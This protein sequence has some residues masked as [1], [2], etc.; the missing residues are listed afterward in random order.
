MTNNGN[1]SVEED[2]KFG[3]LVRCSDAEAADRFEDFLSEQN[4]ILFH[5]KFEGPGVA[6]YFGQASCLEK[7][8]AI[9][10]AFISGQ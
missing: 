6:F 2:K 8:D 10:K 5:V 9:I 1:F 4:Y 3:I 7:I